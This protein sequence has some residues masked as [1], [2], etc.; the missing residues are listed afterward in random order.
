VSSTCFEH[1]AFIIRKTTCTCSFLRYV[2]HAFM[3]QSSRW[4]DVLDS[5]YKKHKVHNIRYLCLWYSFLF[6]VIPIKSH[7]LLPPN[8]PPTSQHV[9]MD[10][11]LTHCTGLWWQLQHLDAGVKFLP[12]EAHI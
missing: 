3:K 11:N 2:F 1:H 12:F 9:Q 4:K 5:R 6:K 10:V 8:A 7:T